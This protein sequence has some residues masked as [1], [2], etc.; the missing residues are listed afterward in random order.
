MTLLV[1]KSIFLLAL[2][3]RLVKITD[4]VFTV[5]CTFGEAKSCFKMVCIAARK[6]DWEPKAFIYVY[7][8]K[9]FDPMD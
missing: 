2:C 7:D 3:E 6:L 5:H 1:T 4:V 9:R 8:A